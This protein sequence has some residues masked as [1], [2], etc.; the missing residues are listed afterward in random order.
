MMPTMPRVKAKNAPW[1]AAN[2]G[3]IRAPTTLFSV[4]PGPGNW[5]CFW[6]HTRATCA[7]INARMMPGNSSTCATYKRGMMMSPGKSPSKIS[8]CI[9][10]PMIGMLIVMPENA[11]RRPVPDSR[12]SGSE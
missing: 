10:V 5:V 3:T 7:A 9:Q 12:S 2:T 11:A 6:Y 1:S 4:R 8:Q